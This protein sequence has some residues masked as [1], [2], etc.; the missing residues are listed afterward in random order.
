L[1][2]SLFLL[3]CSYFPVPSHGWSVGWKVLLKKG[4]QAH[5][6]KDSIDQG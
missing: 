1:W 4:I 3:P 2:V 6:V 5:P